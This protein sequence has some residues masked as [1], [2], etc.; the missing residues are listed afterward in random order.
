MQELRRCS[1]L[2]RPVLAWFVLFLAVS[3]AS[4]LVRPVD[5]E[6]VCSAAGEMKLLPLGA[7]AGAGA[8]AGLHLLDCPACLPLLAP[9]SVASVGLGSQALPPALQM[10]LATRHAVFPSAAPLPARGPPSA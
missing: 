8:P 4:P 1:D 10:A 7:D 5:L 2:A 9:P 6:V 3:V